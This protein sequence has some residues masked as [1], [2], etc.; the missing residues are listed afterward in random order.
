VLRFGS[1]EL[2]EHQVA[3]RIE[4]YARAPSLP[5]LGDVRMM[6]DY[7]ARAGVDGGMGELDLLGIG[8]WPIFGA[9]VHGDDG[10]VGTI[11]E[12]RDVGLHSGTVHDG[13]AV[14]DIRMVAVRLV[15]VVCRVGLGARDSRA[16][17]AIPSLGFLG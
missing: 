9:G 2:V 4:N 1:L 13:D 8:V 11:Q 6:A 3:E 15:T 16:H 10:D 7:D 17:D 14:I 12:A 5:R